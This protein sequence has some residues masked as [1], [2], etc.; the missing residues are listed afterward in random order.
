M[1][2]S[3]LFLVIFSC[4]YDTLFNTNIY[5]LCIYFHLIHLNHFPMI[6]QLI[7]LIFNFYFNKIKISLS[8]KNFIAPR[9]AKLHILRAS[10]MIFPNYKKFF[11]SL[12]ISF[13]K[14]VKTKLQIIKLFLYFR[15]SIMVLPGERQN[16]DS[17]LHFIIH[18]I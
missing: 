16:Q 14:L 12:E 6:H 15:I 11:S 3:V 10:R 17:R 8:S 5:I 18:L 7:D 4:L 2:K 9:G 1:F 13:I